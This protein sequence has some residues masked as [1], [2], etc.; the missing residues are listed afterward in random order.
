MEEVY[1]EYVDFLTFFFYSL[2]L[3]FFPNPY[4]LTDWINNYNFFIVAS[5]IDPKD[6]YAVD[7]ESM[8]SKFSAVKL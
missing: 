4:D 5:I 7:V 1:F 3:H 8:A 2:L 6:Y